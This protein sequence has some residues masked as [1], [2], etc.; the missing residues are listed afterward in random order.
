[1]FTQFKVQGVLIFNILY[2]RYKATLPLRMLTCLR[3]TDVN[4]MHALRPFSLLRAPLSI[5]AQL[6]PEV[7]TI[8]TYG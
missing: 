8:V 1:M 2:Y 5:C 6:Y 7:R 4:I 3:T